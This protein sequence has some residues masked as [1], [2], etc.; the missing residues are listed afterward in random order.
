MLKRNFMC[1]FFFLFILIFS[2]ST[3]G[4]ERRIHLFP[5]IS[6]NCE[7]ETGIKYTGILLEKLLKTEIFDISEIKDFTFNQNL[8]GDI[9]TS[10]KN[11]INEFCQ[12]KGIKTAV[13]GY[14]SKKQSWYDIKIVFYS[15][16]DQNT[17]TNYDDRIFSESFMEESAKNCAVHVATR[18]TS[19]KG[20][21]V[22]V[23]SA[24]C[25]GLG[26]IIQKKYI[27]GAV[28]LGSFVY[29]MY[30]YA[31][32]GNPVEVVSP[33]RTN[34]SLMWISNSQQLY[35]YT[36]YLNDVMISQEEYEQGFEQ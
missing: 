13:Y 8:S 1:I 3:Y 35:H 32:I 16:E 17:I 29:L 34:V 19:I 14:I 27:K 23:A 5:V 12:E 2:F 20:T 7:P 15:V 22:F 9:F 11:S 30:K 31:N 6:L 26:Q 4:Q 18:M 36:Y 24:F 25:P 33:Y 10:L 21:K 28:I